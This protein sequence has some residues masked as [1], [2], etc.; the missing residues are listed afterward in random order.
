MKPLLECSPPNPC[1]IVLFGA[2]GD[3]TARKLIPSLYQLAKKGRL[4]KEFACVGF[5]RRQKNHEIFRKEMHDAIKIHLNL[6]ALDREVWETFSKRLFY[7]RSEFNNPEGYESLHCF[8]QELDH[9]FET[10]G[11]RI[12]Y[13]STPPSSF[14]LIIEK[15]HKHKLLYD[16]KTSLDRWSRIII[17]KPFGHDL[18]SALALEKHLQ[19]YLSEDQI[20]RIDH[21][22]GK[23]TVQNLM[24]LR[25]ANT[26][27][28]ALW[29]NRHID[30]VQI[31]AGESIGIGTRGHYFEETGLLR[32]V[33]Q[34]HL[35]QLLCLVAMEPPVNLKADSIH[36]EKVKVLKAIRPINL[37]PTNPQIIRGQYDC[38]CIN[39]ESV[40]S[41]REEASIPKDSLTETFVAL[42]LFIDNWRWA[43]IPFYLR[44]GKRLPK[45]TTEI[46]V[47]FKD[48]P[49]ILFQK[50]PH[51]NE[52]NFL[53]IRIQPDAGISLK[54]NCK[55]PG[56]STTIQPV[57]M[58]FDYGSTFNLPNPD[59]YERLLSDCISGDST[60]FTRGDE[61][62]GAWKLLT[63][64]LEHWAQT[65]PNNFPNYASGTWGPKSANEMLNKNKRSWRL[66]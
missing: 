59:A 1:I 2:S 26:L 7:H 13:L 65:P 31:T 66:L 49:G 58:D 39:G 29:N 57:K 38:G 52:A 53:A 56:P 30:H 25:F 10:R 14:P 47:F 32:D 11:N 17:E 42:E 48:S 36:D 35:I 40:P 37:S 6:S 15:L 64:I 43:G 44:A 5:A 23:E 41:Y 50:D 12:F 21:Y 3:L 28:E 45:R 8:L 19:K 34:N 55:V 51:R 9:R 22:L 60:L 16:R 20:Y 63:P 33:V 54:I 61:V 18:A 27:F 46:T 24:V 62:L 4:P